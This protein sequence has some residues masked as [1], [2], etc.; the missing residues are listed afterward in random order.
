MDKC[1]QNAQ[2]KSIIFLKSPFPT[3]I[4]VATWN[5]KCP[6]A[7][8][9]TLENKMYAVSRLLVVE[10]TFSTASHSLMADYLVLRSCTFHSCEKLNMNFKIVKKKSHYGCCGCQLVFQK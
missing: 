3:K 5:L 10:M 4:N 6:K 9:Q 2:E 1:V 7:I 8:K